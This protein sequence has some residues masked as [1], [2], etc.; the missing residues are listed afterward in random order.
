MAGPGARHFKYVFYFFAPIIL[1]ILVPHFSHVP[2]IARLSVPPFPFI[3][4]SFSSFISRFALHFTQY[5][6]VAICFRGISRNFTRNSTETV[7]RCSA[8][9]SARFSYIIKRDALRPILSFQTYSPLLFRQITLL[10]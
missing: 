10:I 5:A 2:V 1:N 8:L 6:S 9:I 3:A 7:P 4:T